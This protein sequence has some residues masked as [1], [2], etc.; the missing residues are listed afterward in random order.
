MRIVNLSFTKNQLIMKNEINNTQKHYHPNE[1]VS[2]RHHFPPHH[3]HHDYGV[4]S[5][6]INLVH[7]KQHLGG[8]FENPTDTGSNGSPVND[9][10]PSNIIYK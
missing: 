8:L 4:D 10:K 7:C 5:S 1:P 2:M 9:L 3:R 6:L